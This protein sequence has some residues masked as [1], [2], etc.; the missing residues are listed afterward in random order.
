MTPPKKPNAKSATKTDWINKLYYGDNLDVL[1]KHIADD[2]VDL[3]YLDPPFNSNAGYNVLFKSK[4]GA[5]SQSQIEAFDDTWH[6]DD[7][8]SGKAVSDIKKSGYGDVADLLNAMLDFLGKNDMTAYL[9]MMAVRMIELH[10]VLKPTG[11]FYLHCDPTASHYL[12]LLLD[13]VFGAKQFRNEI[14]WRRSNPK[15]D[16]KKFGNDGDRIL[17][18]SKSDDYF[19]SGIM[20]ELDSKYISK[21]YKYEENGERYSTNPLHAEGLS[22]GGYQYIWNGHARTWR[23]P[24]NRMQELHDS[25]RLHYSKSGLARRKLFLSESK[26]IPLQSTWTDIKYVSGSEK[27]GYPTQKPLALLERIIK[28][29]SAEGD[30]VLDPFCGCG[31]TT[32]AAQKL[33]RKW[34]GI[35]ITPI[36]INLIETRLLKAFK[37]KAKFDVLGLPKDIDGAHE[38]FHR[39]DT[40]KKIFEKWACSLIKALPQNHGKKGAD[41]G[42]DGFLWFGKED[43]HKAIV[44]VKGSKTVG[45]LAVRELD[46]VVK[47]QNAAIGILLTLTPP[48]APM[49]DWAKKAG[50]FKDAYSQK[51]VPRLQIITIEEAIKDK[52]GTIK[53]PMG[54]GDPYKEAKHEEESPVIKDILDD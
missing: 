14:T 9:A 37:K 41:G 46:A 20:G 22:G 32:H 25:G 42:I 51:D 52:E 39:D 31:T 29:S 48:T 2:S 27:L 54:R 5:K 13:A 33:G 34:I 28:A 7:M 30:V 3:I 47:E 11:S 15:N 1:R 50:V 6:W 43:E 23:Y 24:E 53:L 21:N 38:L 19:W 44:S 35:D 49:K 45:V 12:K 10:R 17:F 8:I 26:G 4:S 18:Y 40:T 36:A 16:A